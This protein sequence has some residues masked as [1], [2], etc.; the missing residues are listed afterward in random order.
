MKVHRKFKGCIDGA[1]NPPLEFII[2]VDLNGK[3]KLRN[4]EVHPA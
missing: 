1:N 3:P 2:K 4:E